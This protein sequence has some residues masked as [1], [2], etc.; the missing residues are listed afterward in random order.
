MSG[1]HLY[2][3]ARAIKSHMAEFATDE[4]Y[5]EQSD[6]VSLKHLNWMMC[7]IATRRVDGEKAHRW[8]GYA[9]GVLIAQSHMTLDEA[10]V[11]VRSQL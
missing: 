2:A 8:I 3:I 11:I 4:N 1:K 9:Q 5:G 7:E 6:P 10:R